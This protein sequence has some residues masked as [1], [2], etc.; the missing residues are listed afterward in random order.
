MNM[1]ASVSNMALL[2]HRKLNKH[3][4]IT[5]YMNLCVLTRRVGYG[6]EWRRLWQ[7]MLG[8]WKRLFGFLDG[9]LVCLRY[10]LLCFS[11]SRRHSCIRMACLWVLSTISLCSLV[12]L[13]ITLGIS[14]PFLIIQWIWRSDG[15]K[16]RRS[17]SSK[18]RKSE[19]P[20][21]GGC[22]SFQLPW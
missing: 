1:W 18:V 4:C 11:I 15:P 17:E 16:V 20:W 22:S 2:S 10:P 7:D 12:T 14:I 8:F 19:G 6:L 13:V 5:E 21:G 9:T 3:Q